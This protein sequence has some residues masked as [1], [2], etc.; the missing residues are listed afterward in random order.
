META[1]TTINNCLVVVPDTRLDTNNSP[2]VAEKITKKIED[3][4]RKVIIDFNKTD[5]V[6]SAGL[7]VILVVAK[8]LKPAGGK[9]A[10]CNVN[11]QIFEVLD[12]S[13]F[14]SIVK[15][16]DNLDAATEFVNG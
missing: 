3:G 7:R 1:F 14:H 10:L 8:L 2:G 9:M 15:C 4:E 12:I 11:D 13:G 6:S 16:F 5:Y